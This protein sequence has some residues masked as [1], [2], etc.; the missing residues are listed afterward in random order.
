[1]ALI[2][3][4]DLPDTT[5]PLTADNLNNNFNELNNKI[6]NINSYVST[7]SLSA[8]SETTT[9]DAITV[10]SY[11]ASEEG[12][13]LIV[14]HALPNLYGASGRVMYTQIY[15]NND[16]IINLPIIINDSAFTVPVSLNCI[17]HLE[18]NDVVNIKIQNSDSGKTWASSSSTIY[19]IKLK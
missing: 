15:K 7:V 1:M 3:F 14:G 16:S 8:V 4:K 18:K 12:L 5:T 17:T 13:Y 9:N 10:G 19:I 2:E 6:N 11:T